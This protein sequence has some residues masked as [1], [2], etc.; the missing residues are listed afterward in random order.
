MQQ[1]LQHPALDERLGAPAAAE[2]RQA[3]LEI[4]GGQ[5]MALPSAG[6]PARELALVFKHDCRCA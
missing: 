1:L 6:G 2:L 5:A 4:L 3:A